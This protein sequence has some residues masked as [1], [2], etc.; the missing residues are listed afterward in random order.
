MADLEIEGYEFEGK[1]AS[2]GMME[3]YRAHDREADRPV[4]IKVIKEPWSENEELVDDLLREAR[5]LAR[6][7]HPNLLQVYD[8]GRESDSGRPYIIMQYAE[9]G[10]V[11]DRLESGPLEPGEALRMLREATQALQHAHTEW[12]M[13][14]SVRPADLFLDADE[15]VMLGD[16]A[17]SHGGEVDL[18]RSDELYGAAT[19]MGPEQWDSGE[20]DEQSDIWALGVTFYEMLTGT[21]PYPGETPS[22]IRQELMGSTF[23]PAHEVNSEVPESYH[24]LLEKMLAVDVEERYQFCEELLE[25]LEALGGGEETESQPGVP[26]EE[27]PA[28]SGEKEEPDTAPS[29]AEEETAAGSPAS[30]TAEAT[31][32][33]FVDRLSETTFMVVAGILVLLLLGGISLG[34]LRGGPGGPPGTDVPENGEQR[35]EYPLTVQADPDEAGRVERTPDEQQFSYGETVTLRVRPAEDWQFAGWSDG[36]SSLER[37]Y[38]MGSETTTLTAEFEPR[39]ADRV[40]LRAFTAPTAG[41]SVTTRPDQD[42]FEVGTTVEVTAQ[43]NQGWRFTGWEDGVRDASR[44]VTLEESRTLVA[45]FQRIRH[46]FDVGVRPSGAGSVSA[47][48]SRSS[49]ASGTTIQL[50]ARSADGWVFPGGS[51][52]VSS[53]SRSFEMPGRS[54]SLVARFRRASHTLRT[55][56]EPSAGGNVLRDPEENTVEEGTTVNLTAQ[57][58]EGWRFAGW[59]DGNQNRNRSVTVESDRTLTARF[60]E[61]REPQVDGFEQGSFR[62]RWPVVNQELDANAEETSQEVREGNRSLLI[63]VGP[64]GSGVFSMQNTFDGGNLRDGDEFS[65]WLY[66]SQSPVNINYALGNNNNSSVAMIHFARS[67]NVL[68]GTERVGKDN[69]LLRNYQADVWY[70]ITMTARPG[71]EEV[72]FRIRSQD[73]ATHTETAPSTAA[74][75][76][77]AVQAQDFPGNYDVY[78]DEVTYA[79]PSP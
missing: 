5:A 16:F 57:P 60:R 19:Y 31:G 26:T 72:Q 10:T 74:F 58:R 52:G 55:R 6:L 14:L 37:T 49:Y 7:E 64:T 17:A 59:D 51:D 62:D 73:G 41:G 71:S 42:D 8:A 33:S 34:Y 2:E 45:T 21:K 22:E 79:P 39:A 4:V 56:A 67:G 78:I 28:P 63:E 35:A 75:G 40:G 77:V 66:P 65:A 44:S 13:H 11:A 20:P 24:S 61:V 54:A 27:E 46:D 69:V 25:D 1:L 47:D 76:R 12:I 68:Y 15:R 53:A 48:P 29:E 36:V 38:E 30:T 23:T 3:V 70:E 9:G 50:Q 43:A 18:E 32:S